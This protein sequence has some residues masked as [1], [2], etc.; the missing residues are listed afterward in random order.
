MSSGGTSTIASRTYAREATA[1]KITHL[2]SHSCAKAAIL[3]MM[4]KRLTGIPYSLTL[5]AN[6]E[7]WGGAMLE[8]MRDAEFTIAITD[9]LLQQI[10]QKY[11]SLR[12]EQVLLGRIG[13][14]TV[15]WTPEKKR[16]VA[17]QAFQIMT[18]ARLHYSK[19]H[20]VLVRAGKRLV[21]QPRSVHLTIVGA[22]PEREKLKSLVEELHLEEAVTFTGSLSED[23]IIELLRQADLFVLASH[24][25]PLGVAYME[26]MSMSLPTI[27]TD[28]GGVTEIISS[29]H[30]GLLVPPGN[31]EKLAQEMMRLLDYPELCQNLG[32]HARQTIVNKFDS[33]IGAATLYQRLFHSPVED[34]YPIAELQKVLDT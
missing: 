17:A 12:S 29:G 24:A 15:K 26:A 32:Y 28:A 34:Q 13:V 3:A 5:N 23:Q 1:Q 19:G 25:E 8:K 18:V 11:P 33:R 7:W 22:G 9:W 20:D 21:D 4:L 14:D 27:G 31:D 6:L 16:L 2:H 30:D 10:R